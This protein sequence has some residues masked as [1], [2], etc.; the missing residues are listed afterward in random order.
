MKKTDHYLADGTYVC[1]RLE[2][3]HPTQNPIEISE[4]EVHCRYGLGAICIH[5]ESSLET[6]I[7]WLDA[8]YKNKTPSQAHRP[9]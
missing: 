6:C 7:V 8:F 4:N 2:Q 9:V 1:P 3:L 5:K